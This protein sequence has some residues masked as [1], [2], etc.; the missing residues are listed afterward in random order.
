MNLGGCFLDGFCLANGV[1]RGFCLDVPLREDTTDRSVPS[2]ALVKT[3]NNYLYMG[4]CFIMEML[5]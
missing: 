1:D 4:L 2:L 3:Q 5:C